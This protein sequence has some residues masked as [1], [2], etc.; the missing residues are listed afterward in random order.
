MLMK[1][2]PSSS[3]RSRLVA[4]RHLALDEGTEALAHLGL[5]DPV[6]ALGGD[7]GHRGVDAPDHVGPARGRVLVG[8]LVQAV[9]G[10][11]DGRRPVDALAVA[12][13]DGGAGVAAAR[14]RGVEVGLLVAPAGDV[15]LE[16]ATGA[17][18]GVV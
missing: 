7:R 2:P 3:A 9:D 13:L 18:P 10:Q 11:L 16:D 6:E 4:L 17:P 5:V 15:V 1:R 12:E 14:T 8:R